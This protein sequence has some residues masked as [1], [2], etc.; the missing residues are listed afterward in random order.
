MD[1]LQ[2]M[3]DYVRKQKGVCVVLRGNDTC[4]LLTPRGRQPLNKLMSTAEIESLLREVVP[5]DQAAQL[6]QAEPWSFTHST[7]EGSLKVDVAR[8]DG[9]L[10]VTITLP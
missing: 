9:R 3:A 1:R 10:E 8:P 5:A 6:D 4:V 7:P 2:R